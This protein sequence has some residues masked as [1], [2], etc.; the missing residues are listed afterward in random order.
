MKD[1]FLNIAKQLVLKIHISQMVTSI[2]E[3]VK[4]IA[5]TFGQ[6]FDTPEPV[7]RSVL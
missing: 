5:T 4:R 1:E 3:V 2:Q 7:L 6:G